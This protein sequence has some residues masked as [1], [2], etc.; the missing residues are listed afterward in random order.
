MGYAGQVLQRHA[1]HSLRHELTEP[2]REKRLIV[3]HGQKGAYT[4][5]LRTEHMGC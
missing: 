2:G 4:S 3:V 1:I 5:A